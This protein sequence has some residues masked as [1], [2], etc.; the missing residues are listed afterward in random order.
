[1]PLPGMISIVMITII[2]IINMMIIK[3]MVRYDSQQGVSR[4]LI[5][6]LCL[7]THTRSSFLSPFFNLADLLIII[8]KKIMTRAAQL[9]TPMYLHRWTAGRIQ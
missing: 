5:I 2:A 1:M 3:I 6:Y 8:I 7:L 4:L 9:S